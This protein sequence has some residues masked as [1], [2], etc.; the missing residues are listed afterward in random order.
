[1]KKE[2]LKRANEIQAELKDL[3]A[4][5]SNLKS[6]INEY[7]RIKISS[8]PIAKLKEIYRIGILSKDI[9]T[10]YIKELPIEY[11]LFVSMCIPKVQE[12]IDELEKEL[13]TL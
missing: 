11:D 4:K 5:V 12:Q 10:V 3:E 8:I 2:N 1:M 13:E 9:S 6:A 7:K